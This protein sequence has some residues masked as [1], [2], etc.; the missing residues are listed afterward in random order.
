MIKVKKFL[1]LLIFV[2][3]TGCTEKPVEDCLDLYCLDAYDYGIDGTLSIADV[4]RSTVSF[5][6][7]LSDKEKQLRHVSIDIFTNQWVYIGEVDV[8]E[9]L[10]LL[11]TN[12]LSRFKALKSDTDYIAVM[13]GSIVEDGTFTTIRI[14]YIEFK[15]DTYLPEDISG[16]ISH[17]RVGQSFVLFDVELLSNDYY[18]V[19]YGVFLY[20][21]ETRLDELTVWGSR[22]LSSVMLYH[23]VFADLE[24]NK[25]YTLK[26][27]VIYEVETMQHGTTI[28]EVTFTTTQSTQ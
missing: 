16:E 23:Q 8:L 3:L 21:G 11:D 15:T 24:S 26:L 27:S 13:N 12:Y 19:S 5:E 7:S 25:T 20:E 2:F 14:A 1:I 9:D 6:I 10:H 4:D 18:V 17:I 28:D 22:N